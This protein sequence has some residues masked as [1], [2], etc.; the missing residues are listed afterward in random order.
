[1]DVNGILFGVSNPNDE[2]ANVTRIRLGSSSGIG[3]PSIEVGTVDFFTQS[4]DARM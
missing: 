1:M 3:A 2:R 4:S